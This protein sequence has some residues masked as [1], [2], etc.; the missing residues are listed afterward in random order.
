MLVYRSRRCVRAWAS[1]MFD[2]CRWF[3]PVLGLWNRKLLSRAHNWWYL[4]LPDALEVGIESRTWQLLLRI[5]IIGIEFVY[6]VS[7]AMQLL[8]HWVMN[9]CFAK[10]RVFLVWSWRW[11]SNFLGTFVNYPFNVLLLNFLSRHAEWPTIACWNVFVKLPGLCLVRIR[12]GETTMLCTCVIV[13]KAWVVRAKCVSCRIH[14]V[15]SLVEITWLVKCAWT[16]ILC[17]RFNSWEP[18]IFSK[19]IGLFWR[20]IRQC[21]R[22][23]LVST[24]ERKK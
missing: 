9:S 8:P 13:F 10:G 17:V 4:T 11:W 20:R 7:V 21:R 24:C 18:R 14:E 22:C 1:M 15:L 23:H 12:A 19:G 16:S 5:I 6:S 2:H 3:K